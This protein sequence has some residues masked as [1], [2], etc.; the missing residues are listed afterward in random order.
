MHRRRRQPPAQLYPLKSQI[1]PFYFSWFAPFI[2]K[3]S[4]SCSKSQIELERERINSSADTEKT[5]HAQTSRTQARGFAVLKRNDGKQSVRLSETSRWSERFCCQRRKGHDFALQERP[6]Q[7]ELCIGKMIREQGCKVKP[8]ILQFVPSSRKFLWF[9]TQSAFVC[10]YSIHTVHIEGL[11]QRQ[12][13]RLS[14]QEK[15]DNIVLKQISCYSYFI[16]GYYALFS[17][18]CS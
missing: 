11:P 18:M 10:V 9:L 6:G 5:G 14:M 1:I 8:R 3:A 4:G 15:S 16:S 2:Q 12:R 17:E 13:L 7:T